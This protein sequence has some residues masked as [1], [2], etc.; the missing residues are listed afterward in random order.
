MGNCILAQRG[1]VCPDFCP[2]LA[3]KKRCRSRRFVRISRGLYRYRTGTIYW[4]VKIFG[5]NVW[6]NL[7]TADKKEAMAVAAIHTWQTGNTELRPSNDGKSPPPRFPVPEWLISRP[8]DQ[9]GADPTVP[10][11]GRSGWK[12]VS[13]AYRRFCRPIP[14]R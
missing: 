6:R 11:T 3:P 5:K 7:H 14:T 2:D 4:C 8:V 12:T 1:T 13:A 9:S 10:G